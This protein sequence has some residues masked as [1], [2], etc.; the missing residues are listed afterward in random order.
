MK[1]AGVGA[2]PYYDDGQITLFCGRC[3]DVLPHLAG[4]GI[5][6]V[7]TSPPYNLGNTSGM[8]VQGLGH[9]SATAP[10]GARGGRHAWRSPALANGYGECDDDMPH[11]EY[12]A[13]QH[14]ILRSLWS[15]LGDTGAIYYNHKPRI[16][17]GR[18]IA[19]MAYV[20]PDL[21]HQVRQEIIWARAGGLNNTP[22]FYTN[23]H[24]RIVVIARDDFRL[25]GK[26]ASGVGDVWYIPQETHKRHPD[27]PAPFPLEVPKR[28][29]ETTPSRVIL[30][31]CAGRGTTLVAARL[32]GRRAIGIELSE[33]NCEKA[34]LWVTRA[35]PLGRQAVPLFA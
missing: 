12:V 7:F 4:E 8:G 2:V 19:P 21:L 13:W 25:T 15:L 5:D 16:L 28:A 27:H 3:E 11:E 23:T 30:D 1:G 10:M 14:A 22:A 34:A 26:A 35:Q 29:I 17:G 32:L 24:E 18:L 20:P 9:Y 33:A 6:L 31:P